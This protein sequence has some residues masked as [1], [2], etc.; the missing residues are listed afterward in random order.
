MAITKILNIHC[1]TEGNPAAH[2]KNALEYIRNPDKTEQ[3]RLVGSVN[4]LPD[5][6]YEQMLDTKQVHGKS[7]KRQG[8]HVIISFPPDEVVTP[9]QARFVAEGFMADILKCEY[10]AV[11]G[12]HTDKEHTHIH[13]IWNSVNLVTGEK[14]NSPKGNWKNHLQPATNKYCELLGLEIMPAEYAKNPVN[15]SKEKW[16]YEQSFKDYILNDAKLCLSYAGS[17][18][19]FIFLMKRMGYEFKGKDYLS[20]RIPGMKLYHR[21]D[22]LDDIFSKKELPVILKYGYGQYYQRYQTKGILYVKRANL[23]PMQKRYYA[24]MY[25]LGLIEK[26]CY[27]CHSAEMAKEIKRMQFLQEQYLFI[28]KND[29]SSAADLICLQVEAKQ[30][31][32]DA[33]NRQKEI[34]KECFIRKRKCKTTEDFREYQIWSMD[35]A[36]ELDG[37]KAE[38][39]QAKSDL[40]MISACVSEKLYTA[41]GF[42]DEMEELDYG[43]E[44][45]LPT[46]YDY[47]QKDIA[48]EFKIVESTD[49]VVVDTAKT[50]EDAAGISEDCRVAE[51]VFADT[52]TDNM[53]EKLTT[54]QALYEDF[55]EELMQSFHNNH[56]D[57]DFGYIEAGNSFEL[58]T[59][60]DKGEYNTESYEVFEDAPDVSEKMAEDVAENGRI[61]IDVSITDDDI[62]E[63]AELTVEEQAEQIATA[64]QKYYKSYDYLS[65]ENKARLFNFRI[66]DNSYN[67]QLHA[68]VL[69]KLGIHRYGGDIFEDYQSIYGETMKKAEKQKSEYE[70]GYDDKKRE[71]GRVR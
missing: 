3:C 46:M 15:M 34:Y 41:F 19:H 40:R 10:E 49:R 23:T 31:L 4:C 42:V 32:K 59:D 8:Y 35:S 38:K 54:E 45:V 62:V 13:I 57:D 70:C 18:E 65:V 69:R 52:S 24:K 7:G 56:N 66:D 50:E 2:L 30:T 63:T 43:A 48:E 26:K 6:A 5:S 28:C 36:N 68:G 29:V 67:L 16:E 20:V 12:I 39:K 61:G 64:I 53:I 51:A 11:Y 21:L 22:K 33:G 9:E 47:H 71:R 60:T 55:G 58:P 25:R 1:A 37:L 27:Q 14:Y 17:L 44:D